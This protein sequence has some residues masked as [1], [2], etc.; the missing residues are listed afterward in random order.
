M[1]LMNQRKLDAVKSSLTRFLAAAAVLPAV[2]AIASCG[3]DGASADGGDA[4]IV[5]ARGAG[6]N[7]AAIET[8]VGEF[9]EETGV[10]VDTVELSDTD[11]G[12]KMRLIQQT[13]RSDF[14]LAIAIPGD[15]FPLTDTDGV[16][17]PLDTAGFDPE[18]L[19]ALEEAGLVEDNHLVNQDI[20]PLTVYSNEFADNPPKTWADF[21]D[22]EKYP[23]YRGLQ[24]GGFGVPINIEIALLADGVAPADLYPLDLDRAFAKLDTI[25]DDI[26]LWDAAPKSLQ[27]VLD[28]NTTMTF[29]YSPAALGAVKDGAD[30]GVTLFED[31]PIVRGYAALLEKGPNGPEAGQQF[32]DWWSKPEVQAKYAELTNFGIVLP[33]T[34]VYERL[35]RKDLAYAPF[36]EGQ[37]QGSLLDYEY[38]T[39]TNDAGVSNL[40]EVLNRWNEWRAS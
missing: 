3:S 36:V 34:A 33:S 16:Y 29:T 32:L 5:I 26:T 27:D 22:L 25:K 2:A 9:E 13:G 6:V 7:G 11:Y 4:E 37:E 15:I 12:P 38:Y 20:T 19:A 14:D 1:E 39:E 35:D 24:S 17:A 18:G 10:E 31:A 8:L 28:G 21:F 40:D 23:G 30:V